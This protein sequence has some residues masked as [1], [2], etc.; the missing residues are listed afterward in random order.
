M[1]IQL[2]QDSQKTIEFFTFQQD[3]AAR[4]SKGIE[5]SVTLFDRI[6]LFVEISIHLKQ[7]IEKTE[8]LKSFLTSLRKL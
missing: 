6:T 2:M 4:N 1:S 3:A 8:R 5:N 7:R